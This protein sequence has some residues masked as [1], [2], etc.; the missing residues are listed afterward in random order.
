MRRTHETD[1]GTLAHAAATARSIA[2]DP[3][4]SAGV[5]AALAGLATVHPLAG[6]ASAVAGAAFLAARPRRVRHDLMGRTGEEVARLNEGFTLPLGRE[7]RSGRPIVLSDDD[8]RQHLLVLGTTGSAKT[9][10]LL[11]M[12]EAAVAQGAGL[13]FVDGKGDVSV[14]AKAWQMARRHGRIDDLLVLNLM[15][16]DERHSHRDGPLLSNTMNPFAT[17]TAQCLTNLVVGMMDYHGTH[18]EDKKAGGAKL[19]AG[20]M[21]A[22]VHLRDEG[23]VELDVA[24][25]AGSLSLQ[26]VLALRSEPGLPESAKASIEAYLSTLP[27][28]NAERGARQ[29]QTTIDHH[30]NAEVQ[31]CNVLF[32]LGAH[33]GHVFRNSFADVDLEDVVLNRR[34]LVVILPALEKSGD[35]LANLGKI[36]LATLKGLMSRALESMPAGG[37]KSLLPLHGARAAPFV[38][39]LDEIGYYVVDG[40][41]LVATQARSLGFAMV[42]AASDIHAVKRLNE[43]EAA[44]IIMNTTT[45][46]FLRTVEMD[47][48]AG[49]A[50]AS[51][52][53]P[54]YLRPDT[55]WFSP[56]GKVDWHDI[57][58]LSA[59]EMLVMHKSERFFG[60]CV[61]PGQSTKPGPDWTLR[62]NHFV[63][64]PRARS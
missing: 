34:I 38:C 4:Q 58:N 22:M 5:L 28:F 53:S 57:G 10:F 17:G 26:S 50:M 7:I 18:A 39:V 9:E 52:P 29:S 59:G 19:M 41:A 63:R 61:W 2:R 21:A 15:S 11:G 32:S 47:E 13:L 42:Y 62:A 30:V 44:S 16:S 8:A 35:E 20:V 64:L 40:L 12:S 6:L 27:G 1:Q 54:V 45:R 14:F 51:G 37:D 48:V 33:Y 25:L 56:G 49:L 60:R 31:L 55:T 36:V 23:R 43:R 46:V 24:S 3:L